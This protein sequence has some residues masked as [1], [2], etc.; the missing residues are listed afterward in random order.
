MHG[1]TLATNVILQRTGAP[2]ALVTT[3]GFADLLRLGRAARVEEDR[4]DLQFTP[5]PPPVDPRLTFEVR[6]RI[7]ASGTV[8]VPLSDPAVE[9]VVAQ[10]AADAPAGVAV[11]LLHAYARPDHEHAVARGTAR[12]AARRVRRMLV[13][14]VARDAR[15]RAGDDDRGVRGRRDR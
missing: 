8:L 5:A 6:E 3:E 12:R 13:R 14:R 9:K 15:V 1:T 7:D 11:C 10:V 2:V 4:Y